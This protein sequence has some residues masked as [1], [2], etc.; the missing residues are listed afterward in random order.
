MANAA[1]KQHPLFTQA[2]GLHQQGRLP[3]ARAAY[4]QLL[5]QRPD[6]AGICP[7]FWPCNRGIIRRPSPNL[8]GP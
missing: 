6:H 5:Q 4:Q 7:A 8:T 1:A 2:V 3:E